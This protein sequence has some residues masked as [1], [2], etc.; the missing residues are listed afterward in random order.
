MLKKVS[1]SHYTP[2]YIYL[3][4]LCE[5]EAN[6]QVFNNTKGLSC[7]KCYVT[8]RVEDFVRIRNPARPARNRRAG[9]QQ[10]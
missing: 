9:L 5:V 3:C 8:D 1:R 4:P 2:L 7:P 10:R 6:K